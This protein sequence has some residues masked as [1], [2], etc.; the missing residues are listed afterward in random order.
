MTTSTNEPP[1]FLTV[2]CSIILC[3]IIGYGVSYIITVYIIYGSIILQHPDYNR[4]TGCPLIHESCYDSEKMSCY[5]NDM[6]KC[7]VLGI[8]FNIVTILCIGL[9][10]LTIICV[11]IC[12]QDNEKIIIVND[13]PAEDD[14]IALDE[15]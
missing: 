14:I 11:K 2:L 13:T 12:I 7:Y 6:Q 1:N 8:L 15:D 9:I 10:F 3:T 4:T 5:Q